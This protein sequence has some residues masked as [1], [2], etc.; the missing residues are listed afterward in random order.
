MSVSKLFIYGSYPKIAF[1]PGSCLQ[2]GIRS[3]LQ[4]TEGSPRSTDRIVLLSNTPHDCTLQRPKRRHTELRYG[5]ILKR[6]IRSRTPDVCSVCWL[7]GPLPKAF[8]LEGFVACV[9]RI[10]LQQHIEWMNPSSFLLHYPKSALQIRPLFELNLPRSL[11][12]LLR[13]LWGRKR[14]PQFPKNDIHANG[15]SE[16]LWNNYSSFLIP[17]LE[18]SCGF[19]RIHDT[20]C[21]KKNLGER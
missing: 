2:S 4:P 18:I 5:R 21:A 17:H 12:Y 7:A 10:V 11:L 15:W 6:E 9:S 1:G 3:E 20:F 8:C 16:H 13:V 14:C 19:W